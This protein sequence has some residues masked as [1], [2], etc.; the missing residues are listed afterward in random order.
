MV[1]GLQKFHTNIEDLLLYPLLEV[2]EPHLFLN[3]LLYVFNTWYLIL[4]LFTWSSC[5]T[6]SVTLE[7]TFFFRSVSDPRFIN[8]LYLGCF[9]NINLIHLLGMVSCYSS[10]PWVIFYPFSKLVYKV[11]TV[12]FTRK[13][14][15]SLYFSTNCSNSYLFKFNFYVILCCCVGIFTD[16]NLTVMI[17]NHSYTSLFLKVC[18][19]HLYPLVKR[20]GTIQ[21]VCER[22]I[23][24]EWYMRMIY[25][26]TKLRVHFV[27]L[28]TLSVEIS[29]AG[30]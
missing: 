4:L 26:G 2:L 9:P 5:K 30:V 3:N 22:Y 25:R 16:V 23:Q 1:Q 14:F 6:F 13:S 29:I 8:I 27:F 15:L 20:Q 12:I 18:I 28:S 7:N 11:Q 24:I 21:S 19:S 10:V 17:C